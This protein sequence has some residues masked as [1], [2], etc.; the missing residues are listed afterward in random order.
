MMMRFLVL[1]LFFSFSSIRATAQCTGGISNF[2]YTEGFELT[3]GGWVSGGAGNDWAWGTPAKP[4]IT[5][6]GGGSKCWVIGGLTGTSYT[7]SEASWIQSPCFDFTNLQYPYIEFKVF[8][9]MEQQ[10]DGGSLQFSIDDGASW[11]MVGSVNDPKNCLNENW[12]NYAP[13]T[14]LA[15]L[16]SDRSGWSGNKQASAGSCRGGNGSNG[17][18]TAKH[19]MPYLAG[20]T[21]VLFRFI[22]GAGTICNNYDGFAVDD[23]FIGEAPPNDASFSYTCTANNAVSFTNTSPLCPTAFSWNF[24]DPA[25]GVNNTATTANPSH[26][27]STPGTYMV[28]LTVSGPDNAPST[29]TQ[30]I[31]VVNVLT[32]MLRMAD[33]QTNTGGSLIVSVEGTTDPLNIVWSTTPVQT[34][35]IASNL[36]AGLYT[37]T[38]S[39]AD[40]CTATAIG[41]V[42]TDFSC[43]G[44]YF[45]SAFTPNGDGRNDGFG[46]L[47][48]LAAISDYELSVFNRWGERVFQSTNPL[49]K[50][51]GTVKG[52][53][54][55]ANVFVWFAEFVVP[56]KAK[57]FR[58]GT[59]T[60]IR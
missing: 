43:I 32:A 18:L 37:V 9:E 58:K 10:F 25:S 54:T 27:F 31:T 14:Y 53:K 22:F 2:P 40:V 3:N 55:D 47:G 26:T 13:I 51:N 15:P 1:W 17:W 16:T 21:G 56:G 20:R 12:F 57:E 36:A 35:T 5:A 45:P 34:T 28:T 39:G 8:W 50:W 38:V 59:I 52:N 48:S 29:I 6:A 24:G 23:I 30:P 41:K 46:P 11:A 49:E 44:I 4:V 42:E 33:C 60:L 7:N 19:T